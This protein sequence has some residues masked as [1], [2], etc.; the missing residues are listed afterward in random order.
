[1]TMHD[2]TSKHLLTIALLAGLTGACDRDE[3]QADEAS[4]RMCQYDDFSV[5]ITD[6]P[7]KGLELA[8]TLLFVQEEPDARIGGHLRTTAGDI[9][10]M[11]ATVNDRSDISLA[12]QTPAGT[13]MGL[14]HM[15]GGL[16]DADAI[17]G[18]A[19]GP[20]IAAT[21]DLAA[22]D[23]GHWLLSDPHRLVEVPDY[24][25]EYPDLSM[26]PGDF[27]ANVTASTCQSSGGVIVLRCGFLCLYTYQVCQ[28]GD[29]GGEVIYNGN[30]A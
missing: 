23:R 4:L 17:T 5:E 8:G 12:F 13:V 29:R 9:V 2:S 7:N 30:Q 6:G 22:S 27:T 18:A 1:M 25:S 11:T 20:E 10:P 15:A 21:S 16:C 24:I 3:P 14:G 19:I 28:G 26:P